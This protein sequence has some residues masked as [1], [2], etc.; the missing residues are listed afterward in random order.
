MSHLAKLN[1]K[2]VQRNTQPDPVIAR[3]EKLLAG[4]AEQHKVL[5]AALAGKDYTFSAKR[6]KKN[7]A[8]EKVLVATEKTVRPWFFEQD[9]GWYVQCKYGARPVPLNKDANAV[10]VKELKAVNAVLDAFAAACG[11][12]EMDQQLAALTTRRSK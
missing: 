10:F 1:L 5:N 7:D 8:G 2:T 11:A 4:V 9:G 6:W 12:G 3:R